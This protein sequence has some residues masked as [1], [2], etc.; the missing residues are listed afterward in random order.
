MNGNTMSQIPVEMTSRTLQRVPASE[1][2]R[3]RTKNDPF[4]LSVSDQELFS[5]GKPLV[6]LTEDIHYVLPDENPE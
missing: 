5:A 6:E 3:R 2:T 1:Q 4:L